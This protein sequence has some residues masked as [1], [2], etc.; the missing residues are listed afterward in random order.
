[1]EIK[2]LKELNEIEDFIKAYMKLEVQRRNPT[3]DGMIDALKNALNVA[4][5]EIR[6]VE[7]SKNETISTPWE[8]IE[9][10][11]LY[12][13]LSEYQQGMYIY[14][15]NKYGEEQVKKRLGI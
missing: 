10:R 14:A 3:R 5:T 1:M 8:M 9:N 4:N 15:V 7:K 13:K 11:V 6:N 12:A 2:D